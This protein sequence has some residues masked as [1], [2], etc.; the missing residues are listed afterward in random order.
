[1]APSRIEPATFRLVAQCLNQLRHHVPQSGVAS[2]SIRLGTSYWRLATRWMVWGGKSGWGETFRNSSDRPRGCPR[3]H[4]LLPTLQTGRKVRVILS[5]PQKGQRTTE[6]LV[7]VNKVW[8][9]TRSE[10]QQAVPNPHF[11][12]RMLADR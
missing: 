6:I 10:F 2:Y 3:R 5:R 9:S 11:F 7:M 8:S 4:R 1:M 12:Q